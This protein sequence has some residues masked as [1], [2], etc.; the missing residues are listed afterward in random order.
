MR[1][2]IPF[3]ICQSTSQTRHGNTAAMTKNL[4][5]LETSPYLLQHKDNP[6]HWYPWGDAAFNAAKN[7]DKPILLSI[8]YAACHWCHVMAHESFEDQATADVMNENFINI[9][10]DRE[11]FPD[12]DK[13]YMD[14]LHAFGERGGW[15]LTVF[16]EPDGTPFWGGTYFPNQPQYGRPGFVQVLQALS[17]TWNVEREKISNNKQ[18]ILNALKQNNAPGPDNKTITEQVLIKTANQIVGAT[19]KINGGLSG[20]PKFP[21]TTIYTLLWR[22]YLKTGNQEYR[23]SVLTTL[24]QMCQGG[25]YDHLAGGFARYSV[26]ERW[27][28]PHFEKMLYDNALILD[29]LILVNRSENNILFRKRIKETVSWLLSEMKTPEGAF[30]AS[31]DADS[32]GEEGTYYVWSYQEVTS[33]IPEPNQSVFC[34]YYDITKQGNWEG[35]NIPNRLLY[36]EELEPDVEQL[37]DQ[38][39]ME[40]LNHRI[41]R[42]KP[43]W[44]DKTLTDWNGLT[45]SMLCNAGFAMSNPDWIEAAIQ[46]Y[47]AVKKNLWFSDTLHHA[48]RK[49]KVT[50]MATADDY[51][52]LI[53]AALALYEATTFERYLDDAKNLTD[54]FKKSHW[55]KDTGGYFFTSDKIKNLLVRSCHAHD[56]ATPNANGTMLSNLAKLYQLTGH[57]K[58]DQQANDLLDSFASAAAN[59]PM[60]H[61]GFLTGYLA[62]AEQLQAVL[63]V[64]KKYKD[65]FSLIGKIK[66]GR[67]PI[68]ILTV[69]DGTKFPESH[70]AY[71]KELLRKLPTV[72]ICKGKVCSEPFTDISEI[73]KVINKL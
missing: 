36:S 24:T 47:N 13:L 27:L 59:S 25:I 54:L 12:V 2:Y 58:Y 53:K 7:S 11:E 57:T 35:K 43:G 15:P 69:Y 9:K 63:V 72:Y 46:A 21:Q 49:D 42:P 50:N 44:D 31:Y 64:P 5:A 67:E 32:E 60:A 68:T 45:I 62:L 29:L 73:D 17:H 16:L 8:G 23:Q 6:V 26:D 51:A 33:V 34:K 71:G 70:P 61:T 52:N 1:V 41:S 30:A 40:L 28:A 38:I 19:D 66:A 22:M 20:A 4:L 48:W 10:I 65:V 18:A 56:E 3:W 55:N 37:L 14:A 39:K